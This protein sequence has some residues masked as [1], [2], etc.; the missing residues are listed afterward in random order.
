[1][2]VCQDHLVSGKCFFKMRGA[3]DFDGKPA[4]DANKRSRTNKACAR[5]IGYAWTPRVPRTR[6]HTHTQRLRSLLSCVRCSQLQ[7]WYDVV[8]TCP[9]L[10]LIPRS[11]L[12]R[13]SMPP[14]SRRRS[15][16]TRRWYSRSW[17]ACSSRRTVRGSSPFVFLGRWCAVRAGLFCWLDLRPFTSTMYVLCLTPLLLPELV[18]AS[19]TH[20]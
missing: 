16:R 3:I 4:H 8:Q 13:L 6:T 11:W 12:P 17:F 14:G 9:R 2:T 7:R 10:T 20:T 5:R 15:R 18:R 19:S 1:V